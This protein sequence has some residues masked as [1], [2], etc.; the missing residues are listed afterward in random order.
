[1]SLLDLTLVFNEGRNR[2]EL[3][4]DVTGGQ[5]PGFFVFSTSLLKGGA[6]R[7]GE[8]L[9]LIVHQ[10]GNDALLCILQLENSGKVDSA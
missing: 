4:R 2:E 5:F 3:K 8:G 10:P 7:K 9:F 6:S 1:M